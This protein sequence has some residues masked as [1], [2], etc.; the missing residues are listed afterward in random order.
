VDQRSATF[1]AV[2]ETKVEIDS[3]HKDICKFNGEHAA[4]GVCKA[5]KKLYTRRQ[6][7]GAVDADQSPRKDA[8]SGFHD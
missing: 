3:N 2:T 8:S 1:G 6:A 5:I 4:S 7:V